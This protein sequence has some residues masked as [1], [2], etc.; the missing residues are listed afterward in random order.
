MNMQKCTIY[1]RAYK[2]KTVEAQHWITMG[3]VADIAAP[4][5]VKA[6]LACMKI[7]NIPEP[8][9]K[10]K[11]II[12]IIEIINRIWKEYPNAD[13]Q[14]VGDPD[15]VIEYHPQ[16]TR[17]KDALEWLKVA[18]VCVVIFMGA[19]I[20]V[21]TY[22]TDV[23]LGETFSVLHRLITGEEVQQPMLLTIP[24]SIGIASGVLIFFN[25]FGF[26][27][28]TDDPTPMQVEIKQYELNVEDC[29]IESITDKRRGEPSS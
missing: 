6:K 20:A 24:Y 1:L 2:R 18:G 28:I 27:K 7:F 25:H 14:S 5:D 19:F 9:K 29:E 4:P 3:D 8:S 10:G 21:M 16:V 15:I 12:T 17:P 23:S 11:Y 13:I 26:K 22:N